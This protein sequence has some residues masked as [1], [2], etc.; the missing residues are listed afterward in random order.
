MKKLLVVALCALACARETPPSV[1][2][3]RCEGLCGRVI[4][5]RTK[6][7]LREF[8]VYMFST[9]PLNYALPPG[10][11]HPPGALIEERVIESNDGSFLL[12][13]PNE[14]VILSFTARGHKAFTTK[15]V[16]ASVRIDV[17]LL[18]A[19]QIPGRVT[20]ER[21]RPVTGARVGETV[22]NANGEFVLDEPPAE[23]RQLDV[24]DDRHLP[25]RVIVHQDDA[26]IDVVLRDAAEPHTGA[27]LPLQP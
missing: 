1:A 5:A 17:G 27:V 25:A 23:W 15:P 11:P 24:S 3:K 9:R 8:T 2:P 13:T 22:S 4:D 20:D 10:Y 12:R 6:Q 14:P 18:P 26:R 16:D 21:G 7:P 19:R